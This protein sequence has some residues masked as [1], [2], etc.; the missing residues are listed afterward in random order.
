MLRQIIISAVGLLAFTSAAQAQY[1]Q[2]FNTINNGAITFTGNTLGL[3]GR[4]E[5]ERS[6]HTRGYR[7]VHRRESGAAR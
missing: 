2:R 4:L 1:V 5:S 6:G 7:H 3:D